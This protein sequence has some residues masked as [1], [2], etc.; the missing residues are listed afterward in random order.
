[1][2]ILIVDD[3]EKIRATVRMMLEGAGFEIAEAADGAEAIRTFRHSGADVVLS[4]VFMPDH[5]GLELIRALRRDFPDV[6]VIAMSGG[7]FRGRVD[8]LPLAKGLGAA[9]ILPKPFTQAEVLAAIARALASPTA[10]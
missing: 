5:D 8:M 2:R 1:M 6:K 10:A 4:D 9:A 3:N 7:G